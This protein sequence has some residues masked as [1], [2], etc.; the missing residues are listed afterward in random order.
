MTVVADAALVKV[1]SA[2]VLIIE[3]PVVK[4]APD[5]E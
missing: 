5:E 3:T 2:L 4:S 1:A